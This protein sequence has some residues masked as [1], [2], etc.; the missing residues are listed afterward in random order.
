MYL[1]N[2]IAADGSTAIIQNYL[3]AVDTSTAILQIV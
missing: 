1:I 2:L 3:I